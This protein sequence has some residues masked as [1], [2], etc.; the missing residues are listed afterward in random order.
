MMTATAERQT[1]RTADA[2]VVDGAAASLPGNTSGCR[3]AALPRRWWVAAVGLSL[4]LASC[5]KKPPADFA[6]DPGLVARIT[7]LRI[8]VPSFA[9]PG[10]TI[11][12]AY[13]A[14]L[15]DGSELPF[16]TS[17]DE[18]NPP[19]LHVVFL[20]RYAAS[21]RALG[22][23]NWAL[24][25]DPLVSAVEGFRLRALLRANPAIAAEVVVAP[26]YG[27]LDH[28]LAFV[29]APGR[30][31][32]AGGPGPNV[33]VR[34]GLL[35][36]PFVER[37]IVAEVTVEQAPPLYVLADA[38]LVPPSD[39]L[40]VAA[41]GG[42]G[43]RG[44]DGRAGTKGATGRAGCPGGPGGAG[45]GGGDG[46]PGSDGG[47]GGHVTVIAPEEEPFLAGL[48]E[49]LTDG[50]PAGPGGRPGKGGEGGDG[51][52]AQGDLRR[53]APGPRGSNGPDGRPGPEGRPGRLG[54][55]PQII[56]VPA[57]RVFGARP[58]AELQALLTYHEGAQR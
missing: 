37:L 3:A 8:E 18:D 30:E 25:P 47:T 11:P 10:Q 57:A 49:A 7:E 17:Y 21:A 28:A 40:Q 24:E 27:C 19:M 56:T 32:T 4:L 39:W 52:A 38:E 45:G 20:S 46:G 5:G 55:R 34:L 41:V 14:I 33:T 31:G 36:S 2:G 51:G 29:G 48:V 44:T 9:C 26:D 50:G 13:T 58:R 6:P 43:N 23:G 42:R 16:A 53:C 22:N 15:E 54:P 12:A 35:S 1:G